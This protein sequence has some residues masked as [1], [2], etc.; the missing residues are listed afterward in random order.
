VSAVAAIALAFLIIKLGQAAY[1]GH[2]LLVTLG[3]L[4]VAIPFE[5]GRGGETGR[6]STIAG[7]VAPF[8]AWA[9]MLGL[10]LSGLRL[11]RVVGL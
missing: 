8:T 7:R 3:I 1:D 2:L 6:F 4:A 11:A 9:M 5:V 10:I